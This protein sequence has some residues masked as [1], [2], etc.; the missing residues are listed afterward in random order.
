[1]S[2]KCQLKYL[3]RTLWNSKARFKP[4]VGETIIS[5]SDINIASIGVSEVTP[6]DRP[7]FW[8]VTAR[9]T[10]GHYFIYSLTGYENRSLERVKVPTKTQNPT[11]TYI[12]I[13]MDSESGN[14]YA[15]AFAN[16]ARLCGAKSETF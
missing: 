2:G 5:L 4:A 13:F 11:A 9:T 6:P 12:G 3:T 16:A 1:M 14:R 7:A 10:Q 8:V 15:K